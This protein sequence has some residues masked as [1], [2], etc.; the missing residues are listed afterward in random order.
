MDL[1]SVIMPVHNAGDHLEAAV[2]SILQ[3]THRQLELLLVDDRSNDGAIT[4]LPRTDPRLQ[5][6]RARGSGVVDAFNTGLAA[7]RGDW[8]ARMDGDDL[9]LPERL[10]VQLAYLQEHPQLAMAGA[11][12]ELFAEGGLADGNRHYE[13]WLNRQRTPEQIRRALFTE[14]PMPNPTAF[15][16]RQ[17]LLALG[18]YA[19]PDWPEDYDLFLRAD[20]LGMAMGKPEPVLLRWR[21]H[22]QRLTRT[23]DR[24]ARLAFQRA[25]AHYLVQ[26]RGLRKN[27]LIWG[28][29][30]SGRDFHDLLLAEGAQV[31]AF[32]DVHPRRIGGN[33]RGL[34]VH[35]IE[36]AAAWSAG[37]VLVAVGA[38]GARPEIRRFLERAGRAEGKDFLFI[39]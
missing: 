12:V 36:A 3:Q 35:A 31:S 16:R 34:P 26:A 18:G 29:G 5:L 15:F 9:A 30:P 21:D 37:M 27:L 13:S 17:A 7:A 25:K 32:V 19:D 10:A 2:A 28:A 22:G 4:A 14:S 11:C 8:I 33:K 6:L 20:A 23:S 1:I 39:A 24:Y 38:R